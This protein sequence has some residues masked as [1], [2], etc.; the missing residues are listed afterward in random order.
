MGKECGNTLEGDVGVKVGKAHERGTPHTLKPK[1]QRF[2][3][4]KTS[5]P[6]GGRNFLVRRRCKG[7]E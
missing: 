7:I 5:I 4:G 1:S 6:L 3:L 2:L